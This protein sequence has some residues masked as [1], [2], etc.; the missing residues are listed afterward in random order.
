M[1]DFIGKTNKNIKELVY[2]LS[3]CESNSKNQFLAVFNFIYA[4]YCS[5]QNIYLTLHK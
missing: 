5:I 3:N 4:F 1:Y 2:L